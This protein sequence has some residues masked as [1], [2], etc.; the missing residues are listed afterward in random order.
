MLFIWFCSW[1]SDPINLSRLNKENP[2]EINTKRDFSH[3]KMKL[4]VITRVNCI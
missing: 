2:M 3:I 4:F 1:P